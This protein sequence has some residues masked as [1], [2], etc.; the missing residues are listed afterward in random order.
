MPII[1][2]DHPR[3][4]TLLQEIVHCDQ[5]RMALVDHPVIQKLMQLKWDTF[6]SDFHWYEIAK[7]VRQRCPPPSSPPLPPPSS[8]ASS[9]SLLVEQNERERETHTHTH[10]DRESDRETETQRETDTE[11]TDRILSVYLTHVRLMA[12]L[13]SFFSLLLTYAQ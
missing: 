10:R 8:S 3:P 5:D 4:Y 13:F 6:A 11:D 2:I 7:Y 1:S 9:A 12:L